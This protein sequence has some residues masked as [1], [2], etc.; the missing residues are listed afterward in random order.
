MDVTLCG[1]RKCLCGALSE[2]LHGLITLTIMF[3]AF[4]RWIHEDHTLKYYE[5]P[6]ATQ[7]L[8]PVVV[9]T[10][11]VLGLIDAGVSKLMSNLS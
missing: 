9:T 4:D 10:W 6:N 1:G 3:G 7:I 5:K 11:L 2:H 8:L